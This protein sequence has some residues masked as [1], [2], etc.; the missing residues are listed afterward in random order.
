ME[1]RGRYAEGSYDG[2]IV[3]ADGAR[4]IWS[5]REQA[6]HFAPEEAKGWCPDCDCKP[7]VC[8]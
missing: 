1:R 2:Q 6:W 4:M 8:R 3:R 5:A 7:C